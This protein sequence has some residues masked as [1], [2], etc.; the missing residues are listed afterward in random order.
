VTLLFQGRRG[1][2]PLV[3]TILL[4]AF[5]VGVGAVVMSVGESYI[6]EKAEFVEGGH[7]EVAAGCGAA[8]LSVIQVGGVAQACMRGAELELALD[9]GPTDL[10][11]VHLRAVGTAGI[12]VREN[13]LSE[14]L[15]HAGS[16]QAKASLA[17]AGEVRQLK[18]T[19]IIG[20]GPCGEQAV[21]LENIRQC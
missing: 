15:K 13:I 5:S 7:S 11:G 3:A 10:A 21:T 1:I 17:E 16:V 19:P 4:I 6:E 8:K 20:A 18:L 14:P 9:N 12:A 2:S